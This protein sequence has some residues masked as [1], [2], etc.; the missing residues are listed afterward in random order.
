VSLTIVAAKPITLINV[1]RIF[2]YT[3]CW[4]RPKQLSHIMDAL[5]YHIG[6]SA[7]SLRA[8]FQRIEH[9]KCIITHMCLQN[10]YARKLIYQKVKLRLFPCLIKHH[11]MKTYSG[12]EVKL[13]IVLNLVT[14]AGWTSANALYLYSRDALFE[15][16]SQYWLMWPKFS[17]VVFSSVKICQ[18]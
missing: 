18:D 12:M 7:Y 16:Q 10:Y 13:H 1:A 15:S 8:E 14:R 5:L 9:N 4:I 6:I 3:L 2:Y 17:V 11:A